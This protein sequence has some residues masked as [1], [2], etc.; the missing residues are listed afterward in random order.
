M[1][2][3]DLKITS[4]G[5]SSIFNGVIAKEFSLEK[6]NLIDLRLLR[7]QILKIYDERNYNLENRIFI[8]KSLENFFI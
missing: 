8:D 5:E 6:K 4:L 3:G 2:S 1:S 7:D